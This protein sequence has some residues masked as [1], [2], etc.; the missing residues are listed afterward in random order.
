MGSLDVLTPDLVA[1]L[2]Y[3][4]TGST[5][6]NSTDNSTSSG[7]VAK[8]T[9]TFLYPSVPLD[10][11]IY[12]TTSCSAGQ[13][14]AVFNSSAAFAAAQSTWPTGTEFILITAATS[15]ENGTQNSFFL[16]TSVAFS[17]GDTTAIATGTIVDMVDIFDDL[18]LDFG[19]IPTNS[20]TGANSTAA[21]YVCGSP[22]NSTIDGL[23][24]VPCG[25]DFDQTLDDYLGYYS[26][27]DTDIP[28]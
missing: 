15:C 16:A 18:G 6:S 14:F 22:D 4:S 12:I 2:F 23:P 3:G 19:A 5:D 10:H 17:T 9:I 20:T 13:L 1:G 25:L 27:A 7:T 26:G 11:S 28:V 24:T 21:A 8:L